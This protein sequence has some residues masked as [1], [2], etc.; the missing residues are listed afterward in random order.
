MLT[1]HTTKRKSSDRLRELERLEI[2]NS[3]IL[4]ALDAA[5]RPTESCRRA[6]VN[7][8]KVIAITLETEGAAK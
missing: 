4:A 7:L 1:N 8:A 5:R 2:E 3:K 6:L